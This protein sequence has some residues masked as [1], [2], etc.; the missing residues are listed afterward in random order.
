MLE[1]TENLQ[2]IY[3]SDIKVT[4]DVFTIYELKRKYEEI[5]TIQLD[6]D[7][8]RKYVWKRKQQSELIESILMGIPLPVMYFAEDRYGNL[9]VIDGRQRLTAL[10]KYLNNE[11][12]INSVSILTY[13]KGKKFKDLELREQIKLEDYQLIIY[14]IQP[15]TPDRVKFDIFDRVN[16]GGTKL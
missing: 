13:L 4:K 5:K 8:Q 2:D 1:N 3:S 15:Q 9:Q 16:R 12:S 7:F 14:I 11:F 6:P 10:F